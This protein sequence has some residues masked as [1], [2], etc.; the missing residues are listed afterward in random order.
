MNFIAVYLSSH[1][2]IS[3][4]AERPEADRVFYIFVCTVPTGCIGLVQIY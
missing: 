1:Q 3:T 2:P 4:V